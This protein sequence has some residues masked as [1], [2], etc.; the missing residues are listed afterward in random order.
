M[1]IIKLVVI[2]FQK[3]QQRNKIDDF[4]HFQCINEK[5]PLL[6]IFDEIFVK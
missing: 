5:I 6:N 2:Q 3:T 1:L 4:L